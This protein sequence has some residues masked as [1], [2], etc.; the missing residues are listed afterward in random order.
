MSSASVRRGKW[1]IGTRVSL[2][3]RKKRRGQR[4]VNVGAR[5]RGRGRRDDDDCGGDTG[6]DLI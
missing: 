4:G 6:D 1:P 2:S 5:G 3:S